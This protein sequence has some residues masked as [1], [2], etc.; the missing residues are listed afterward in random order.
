MSMKFEI[1]NPYK[2]NVLF[3]GHRQTVQTQIRYSAASDQGLHCWLTECSIKVWIEMKDTTIQHQQFVGKI[4]GILK[5]M[6]RTYFMI[7]WV[8]H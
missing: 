7:K 4:V 6:T 5:V 8:E 2:S 3:V 1:F